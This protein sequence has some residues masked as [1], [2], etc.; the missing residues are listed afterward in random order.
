MYTN[1]KEI[2][3]SRILNFPL[4]VVYQAF[5]N[6]THLAKWWG[7]AGFT[8]TFHEFELK[9]GGKWVLTMH[10]PEKGNYENSSIFKKV[11]PLELISWTRISKPIFDMDVAFEKMSDSQTRI[12]FKMI[13]STIEECDK[14]RSFAEPKNEENF[15]KLEKELINIVS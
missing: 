6:P 9:P 15:D 10:G 1:P 5:A 12:S 8:N 11:E 2:Y 14:I 4:E 3:S 7:P 13:F